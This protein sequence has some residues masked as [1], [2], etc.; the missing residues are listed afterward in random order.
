M[1]KVWSWLFLVGD[2]FSKLLEAAWWNGSGLGGLPAHGF[3]FAVAQVSLRGNLELLPF[4]FGICF[5]YFC[6]LWKFVVKFARLQQANGRKIDFWKNICPHQNLWLK[7]T[8]LNV[9]NLWK[10]LLWGFAFG[11][12]PKIRVS[13]FDRRGSTNGS[14]ATGPTIHIGIVARQWGG[15]AG[16]EF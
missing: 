13:T 15:A 2:P 6:V 7:K 16:S 11:N 5:L 4:F 3:F 9:S 8:F 14:L 1:K 12:P 10:P